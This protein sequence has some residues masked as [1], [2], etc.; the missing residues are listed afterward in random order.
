[1]CDALSI[2]VTPTRDAQL[3]KADAE[4]LEVLLRLLA[5]ARSWPRD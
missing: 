4:E 3:A 5:T 1:L 2:E